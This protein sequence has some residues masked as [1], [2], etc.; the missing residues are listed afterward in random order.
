MFHEAA[1]VEKLLRG[2]KC[3]SFRLMGHADRSDTRN[4]HLSEDGCGA[5]FE[6]SLVVVIFN[7]PDLQRHTNYTIH[8]PQSRQ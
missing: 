5:S 1:A 4:Q 8:P 3:C 6:L 2:D 7:A